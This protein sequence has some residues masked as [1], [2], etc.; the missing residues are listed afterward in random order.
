MDSHE[1]VLTIYLAA[2]MMT[3]FLSVQPTL[4]FMYQMIAVILLASACPTSDRQILSFRI[5]AAIAQSIPR[6]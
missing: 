6:R 4:F 1:A 3:D 2:V 5:D